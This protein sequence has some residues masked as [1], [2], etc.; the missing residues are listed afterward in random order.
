MRVDTRSRDWARNTNYRVL[1]D[2]HDVT[3]SCFLADDETGEVGVYLRDDTGH[4]YCTD[5]A[6]GAARMFSRGVVELIPL[7]PKAESE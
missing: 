1:F 6:K 7:T 2:G 3:S 4:H 5:P